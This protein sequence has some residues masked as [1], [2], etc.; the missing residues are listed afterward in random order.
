MESKGEN[1]KYKPLDIRDYGYTTS[2]MS[3]MPDLRDIEDGLAMPDINTV[4]PQNP[5]KKKKESE[6][7]MPGIVSRIRQSAE[8]SFEDRGAFSNM[9]GALERASAPKGTRFTRNDVPISQAYDKLNDGTY[10]PRYK[11]FIADTNNE[12]RLARQQ[13]AWSKW[14]NGVAK[15]AIKTG[16]YFTGNII[17]SSY[18]IIE[19]MKQGNF[20]AVY[21]NDFMDFMNDLEKRTDYGFANYY[22]NEEKKKSFLGKM[23]TANFWA[24]DV[25]GGAAYTL[26]A[27]TSEALIAYATGGV[28]LAGTAAR[29]ALRAAGK[30]AAKGIGKRFFSDIKGI[31]NNY[32]RQVTSASNTASKLHNARFLWTSAGWEASVESYHYMKEA[33]ANFISSYESMYGR[34]PT[35]VELN[36]FRSSSA[37]VG[38]TVFAANVGIVGLSNILQFGKYF[39]AGIDLE[40]SVG[41]GISR[42]F[43]IGVRRNAAG[44]LEKIPASKFRKGLGTVFHVTKHPLTE[45]VWEEGT[46]GVVSKAADEWIASRYNPDAME[47]NL[48][49][50]KSIGEGFAKTYGTPEGR[51]EIGIGAIIGGFM[52]IGGGIVS[53]SSPFTEMGR[54]EKALDEYIENANK[55]EESIPRSAVNLA[56][57]MAYMNQ[58]ISAADAGVEAEASGDKHAS[59]Q[60]YN[61]SL[62]TKFQ[63]DDEF[64]MLD[65]SAKNFRHVINNMSNEDIANEYNISTEEAARVKE[66]IVEDYNERLKNYKSASKLAETLLSGSKSIIKKDYLALNLFLGSESLY[67]MRKSAMEI[68]DILGDSD[69]E[70]AMNYYANLTKEGKKLAKEAASI[71]GEISELEKEIQKINSTITEEGQREKYAQKAQRL[72]ELN[73]RIQEIRRD[74]THNNGHYVY[75]LLWDRVFPTDLLGENLRSENTSNRTVDPSMLSSTFGILK[76]I[77]SVIYALNKSNNPGDKAKAKLLNSLIDEYTQSY[78][79]YRS[80]NDMISRMQDPKFMA[81]EDARIM[82]LFK[83]NGVEYEEDADRRP[84]GVF[85]AESEAKIDKELAEGNLTEEEA[86]TLKTFI[87][88]QEGFNRPM[89][90]A[91]IVSDEEWEAYNQ[92]DESAVSNQMWNIARIIQNEGELSER[93]KDIYNEHAGEIDELVRDLGDSPLKRLN[94]LKRKAE[95]AMGIKSAKEVN[96]KVINDALNSESDFDVKEQMK[97]AIDARNALK[98]KEDTD[99]LSDDEQYKLIELENM[100]NDFGSEHNVD[101]L[102]DFIE[103]NRLIEKGPE[104]FAPTGSIKNYNDLVDHH[105]P[106]GRNGKGSSF[107]NAQNIK[108]LTVKEDKQKNRQVISGIT[109]DNFV[110]FLVEKLGAED[111]GKKK[112]VRTVRVHGEEIPLHEGKHSTVNISNEDVKKLQD[113]SLEE[114]IGLIFDLQPSLMSANSRELLFYDKNAKDQISIIPVDITYGKDG[115]DIIKGEDVMETST[116]DTVEA[117]VDMNDDYNNMLYDRYSKA[118]KELDEA[119]ERLK[120]DPTNEELKKDR[121]KAAKRFANSLS[122]LKNNLVIKLINTKGDKFVSVVK[123]NTESMSDEA[124]AVNLVDLRED[125]ASYFIERKN[126]GTTGYF[127]VGNFKVGRVLPG[128][129]TLKMGIDPNTNELTVQTGRIAKNEVD[130]FVTVGYIL[131]G[132]VHLKTADRIE[133]DNF[134]FATNVIRN[135][136]RPGDEYF[137]QKMPVV[138]IKHKNGRNYVYPVDTVEDVK[139]SKQSVIDEIDILLDDTSFITRE[140]LISL[141]TEAMALGVSPNNVARIAGTFAEIKGDLDR[142]KGEIGNMQ[143]KKDVSEWVNGSRTVSEILTEDVLINLDMSNPFHAPKIFMDF[144]GVNAEPVTET[145]ELPFP[146]SR[147]ELAN[148]AGDVDMSQSEN[149]IKNPC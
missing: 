44:M 72:T 62:F 2:N 134:P 111:L 116:D 114:G 58:Q 27:L 137:G 85:T 30:N 24:N 67:D 1:Y 53:K 145:E 55:M 143:D 40:K 115:A 10:I 148:I 142:M 126:E 89:D 84:E 73:N 26:G 32:L 63:M 28:S 8:L 50:W 139:S 149:E 59:R 99:G 16:I 5:I 69:V 66:N 25:F 42:M 51:M 129:P 43:G 37:A 109:V 95:E 107:D 6:A 31:T 14:G 112:R 12:E 35:E 77:D 47:K 127:N 141:N 21:N 54:Q 138:V 36:D 88:M 140:N 119:E 133:Y 93:Q 81:N 110:K 68:G 103:Q 136:K 75:N 4:V 124:G 82:K 120:A 105:V 56:T 123:A 78:S 52:G 132:K 96:E 97:A 13:S 9:D 3:N 104:A 118:K 64:G 48:S 71:E 122:D 147:N 125:A 86:Y 91:D 90:N 22:T 46:Q 113:R 29:G 41:K 15:L 146:E 98:D 61:T 79:D 23:G 74:L 108:M 49:L 76:N 39:G 60:A 100:I 57:R 102:L 34:R 117:R 94:E 80:V 20:S 87:R 19:A 144:S 70:S 45:G 11:N 38:N 7:K 33:E 83:R 128:R 130:N 101:N 18:G 131:N 65:D 135:G 121:D 92:G 17:N 106:E